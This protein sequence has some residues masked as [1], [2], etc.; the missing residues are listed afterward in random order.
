MKVLSMDLD[1]ISL[2]FIV[3]TKLFQNK[4][5]FAVAHDSKEIDSIKTHVSLTCNDDTKQSDYVDSNNIDAQY[6]EWERKRI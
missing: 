3:K 2:I 4:S 6:K 1:F 5:F